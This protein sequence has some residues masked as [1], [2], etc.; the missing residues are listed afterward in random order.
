MI[1]F[2]L[3]HFRLWNNHV[4]KVDGNIAKKGGHD[5]TNRIKVDFYIID[6]PEQYPAT[7]EGASG[8]W[9]KLRTSV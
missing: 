4:V 6:G 3:Y 7:A 9:N 8:G 1:E 2:K 5:F